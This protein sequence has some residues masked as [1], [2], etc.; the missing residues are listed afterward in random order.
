MP[1]TSIEFDSAVLSARTPSM[2]SRGSLLSDIEF[3]P[4]MRMRAPEPVEPLACWIV[5]PEALPLSACEK[6]SLGAG[7]SESKETV[8]V[9]A[10][11]SRFRCVSPEAAV[12]STSPRTTCA[13]SRVKFTVA[14]PPALT[15]APSVCA[16]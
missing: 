14:V 4:R 3:D 15:V 6:F 16:A 8:A 2:M 9:D 7:G 5:T 12:T 10:P 1:P 13:T 11:L